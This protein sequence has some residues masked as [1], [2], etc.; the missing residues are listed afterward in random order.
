[1]IKFSAPHINA[2]GEARQTKSYSLNPLSHQEKNKKKKKNWNIEIKMG[3]KVTYL[4]A[5]L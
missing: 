3:D 1:M 4:C 5:P 2:S